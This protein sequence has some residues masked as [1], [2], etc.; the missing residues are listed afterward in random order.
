L[1]RQLPIQGMIALNQG[2]I[3]SSMLLAGL[4]VQLLEGRFR[5]AVGWATAAALIAATG[6]T[7]GYAVTEHGIVNAYGPAVTWPFVVGYLA[8][9]TVFVLMGR[10]GVAPSRA[11]S[12]PEA[13]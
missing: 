8:M 2:F 10:G 7:H 9:A 5:A 1:S 11:Q 3:L 4:T 12:T 13:S 6:L